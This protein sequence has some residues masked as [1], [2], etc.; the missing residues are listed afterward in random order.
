MHENIEQRSD[1]SGRRRSDNCNSSEIV[2][3][4]LE[5]LQK[6]VERF[7]E[8][9][10]SGVEAHREYHQGLIDAAEAQ[11]IFWENLTS[12]LKKL[13]IKAVILVVIGLITVKIFG[14]DTAKMLL[15][16]VM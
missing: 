11:K 10:P 13:G 4:K 9:F 14:P 1:V 7:H 2:C 16:F 5:A 3:E 6:S 15:K 8:A 12:D